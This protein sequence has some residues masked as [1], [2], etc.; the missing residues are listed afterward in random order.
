MGSEVAPLAYIDGRIE[1]G[2]LQQSRA[3][4]YNQ[5]DDTAT[6]ADFQSHYNCPRH[7]RLHGVMLNNRIGLLYQDA[8]CSF[9]GDGDCYPIPSKLLM[10]C[11]GGI[12]LFRRRDLSNGQRTEEERGKRK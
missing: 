12:A 5:L 4:Y 10:E 7:A 3:G 1:Y 11:S 8:L 6:L 2:L 9:C